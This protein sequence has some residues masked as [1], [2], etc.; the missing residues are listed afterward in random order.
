MNYKE[1]ILKVTATYFDDK[2]Q[3]DKLFKATQEFKSIL[4]FLS[5]QDLNIEKGRVDMESENGKAIGAYWAGLCLDDVIRTRQFI[6][7]I[8]RAV[9]EQLKEKKKIHILYAGTGPFATLIMPI[10]FKYAPEQISY[11]FLEINPFTFEVLQKVASKIGLDQYHITF[12]NDNATT[13][14]INTSKQPDVIISETMQNSLIKEQQVPIYMNLMK[15][16]GPETVFIP[17][18][19]ALHFGFNKKAESI[20]E[21]FATSNI[22]PSV[23]V[24]EVSKKSFYP[25][26]NTECNINNSEVFSEQ[27]CTITKEDWQI[28]DCLLLLTEIVIYK[29]ILLPYNASGLTTPMLIEKVDAFRKNPIQ[30]TSQYKISA[31]PQL[32]YSI[33]NIKYN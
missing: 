24:F 9:Q 12:V 1:K 20:E 26:N 7:G 17:E 15:Q 2:I 27:Q 14:Q 3:Y 21:Q 22:Y 11:T 8:D 6:R 16:V 25:S 10:I 18:K 19:I 30:I 28:Y 4:E 13:Y 32:E 23:N 29:D 33:D 31:Q 5:E